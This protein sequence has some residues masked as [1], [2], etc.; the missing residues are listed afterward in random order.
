MQT[1]K[2]T[3]AQP[4]QIVAMNDGQLGQLAQLMRGGATKL[5][6]MTEAT[7]SAWLEHKRHFGQIVVLQDWA[8]LRQ[9]RELLASIQEKAGN[10][11]MDLTVANHANIDLLLA[12]IEARFLPAAAGITARSNYQ[13]S[14]QLPTESTR[15]WHTR[16]RELF[17]LA[18]PDQ[19]P[20]AQA[21]C[22]N[23]FVNGLVNAN[24]RFAAASQDI[25][26][27][28]AALPVA[29]RAETASRDVTSMG[30]MGGGISAVTTGVSVLSL[31]SQNR[32]PGPLACYFCADMFNIQSPHTKNRCP[33][34]KAARDSYNAAQ[35]AGPTPAQA[36][37][38]NTNSG[39]RGRGRRG[40]RGGRARAAGQTGQLV[41]AVGH[42]DASGATD[43]SD[44]EVEN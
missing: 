30:K 43:S 17:F 1:N 23:T 32:P 34:W 11:V 31:G 7:P 39:R 14:R 36:S 26:N 41:N 33:Y 10:A 16:V 13:N 28:G 22:L 35:S 29:E 19:D 12:A 6:R 40:G 2:A 9:R 15:E 38:S 20:N 21:H 27:F 4:Q 3:M 42:Y 25:A 37:S 8:D 5:R 44:T 24:V 18:Y